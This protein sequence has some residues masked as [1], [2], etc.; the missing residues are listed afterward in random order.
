MAVAKLQFRNNL[1]KDVE[2]IDG[3]GGG[4]V[5]PKTPKTPKTPTTPEK[6]DGFDGNGIGEN[7]G[8]EKFIENTEGSQ[9]KNT[10]GKVISKFL[11]DFVDS[12]V[13]NT[14]KNPKTGQQT[15][16]SKAD[17]TMISQ[18]GEENFWAIK[19]GEKT[20]EQV[21]AELANANKSSGSTTTSN[22]NTSGL[23]ELTKAVEEA[24]AEVE[25][26][27][28]EIATSESR[29]QMLTNS[30]KAREAQVKG[31]EQ[32]LKTYA[33]N[34]SAV[35]G[36]TKSLKSSQDMLAKDEQELEEEQNKLT[37][38]NKK[39][40][41]AQANQTTAEKALNEAKANSTTSSTAPTTSEAETSKEDELVKNYLNERISSLESSLKDLQTKNADQKA[42]D[43]AEIQELNA[44]KLE[45]TNQINEK[46]K[47][48]ANVIYG[49][50]SYNEASIEL[51]NLRAELLSVNSRI[52][53][54]K[55]RTYL[56]AANRGVN[57]Q[58]KLDAAK[59]DLADLEAGKLSQDRKNEIL[60]ERSETSSS[61]NHDDYEVVDTPETSEVIETPTTTPTTE[62][63][64]APATDKT[65]ETDATTSDTTEAVKTSAQ[66]K[67]ETVKYLNDNLT[68]LNNERSKL[69]KEAQ[70]LETKYTSGQITIE[71]YNRYS[72]MIETQEKRLQVSLNSVQV[73]LNIVNNAGSENV[74]T[75]DDVKEFINLNST[76]AELSNN[77]IA[78]NVDITVNIAKLATLQEQ[79]SEL[80]ASLSRGEIS[81]SQYNAEVSKL[82]EESAK[83]MTE[84]ASL[85]KQ[86]DISSSNL[87]KTATALRK[88][89]DTFRSVPDSVP[90]DKKS[91]F[92]D[93]QSHC[94]NLEQGLAENSIQQLT[95]AK[96]F[97]ALAD[98]YN[99]GEISES[100]YNSKISN[101]EN[102]QKHYDSYRQEFMK[103]LASLNQQ[104]DAI[105]GKVSDTTTSTTEPSIDDV[106]NQ[107]LEYAK[108]DDQVLASKLNVANS[109]L[110]GLISSEEALKESLNNGTISREDYEKAIVS[111]S[112]QEE[113]YQTEID[114]IEAAKTYKAE[115]AIIDKMTPE[116]QA[117]L[118]KI[119][120][121]LV[122]IGEKQYE[123]LTQIQDLMQQATSLNEQYQNGEITAEQYNKAFDELEAKDTELRAK[124]AELDSQ[125]TPLQ[126]RRQ[127]LFDN[128]GKEE[129]VGDLNTVFIS[130]S[131]DVKDTY[132]RL[133]ETAKKMSGFSFGQ[134]ESGLSYSQTTAN[135]IKSEY[136]DLVNKYNSG[137]ISE[138]EFNTQ[139]NILSYEAEKAKKDA[140]E[141]LATI[142]YKN[143]QKLNNSLS[144]EDRTQLNTL[145]EQVRPLEMQLRE[146]A[147]QR[148]SA[149]SDRIAELDKM[150]ENIGKV[151]KPYYEKIDEILAKARE[152]YG[153]TIKNYNLDFGGTSLKGSYAIYEPKNFKLF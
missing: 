89:E 77:L 79:E 126:E 49:S 137:L 64:E 13:Q 86:R 136:N 26:I 8:L 152:E 37:E 43:D 53:Y 69:E 128:A 153:A 12:I 110:A 30:K 96:Q 20:E 97:D 63:P 121:D 68:E 70:E 11:N 82:K 85:T 150:A 62:T 31:M 139:R 112:E 78:T 94:S 29:I 48:S 111:I 120:N 9:D 66:Q 107:I 34:Q 51:F 117:E 25:S 81:Q 80:K 125:T 134:L 47:S 3:G 105:T 16:L 130:V 32:A 98:A 102:L 144:S 151:L 1:A 127:Y 35:D 55:S 44:K 133:Q 33:S 83:L 23:D 71:Q 138:T 21:K 149:T 42:K 58:Q 141:I 41:T 46:R 65:G 22:T 52:R 61:I 2:K 129:P 14:A 74:P 38:L 45:L 106:Q 50:D 145:K 132:D 57:L 114:V 123:I 17:Q 100:V 60:K 6:T 87:D 15:I 108:L 24:K 118:E 7:A 119:N 91:T 113:N 122:A 28:Q 115:Q 116:Q 19:N 75:V 142:E 73:A 146:I 67:E 40:Q 54:L 92:K 135:E 99:A 109:A 93:M 143:N 95:I 72:S 10:F 39:L 56:D 36:I 88:L 104:M 140:E 59:Q 76:Y 90:E 101:L 18:Y 84:Q 5:S 4:V 124:Y 103:E 131:D 147:S 148:E 27:K